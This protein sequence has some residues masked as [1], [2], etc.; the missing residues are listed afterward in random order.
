LDRDRGHE[1]MP[2]GAKLIAV[3]NDY[4]FKCE[5]CDITKLFKTEHMRKTYVKLHNKFCVLGGSV[6]V[7]K[8]DIN[9]L[10]EHLNVHTLRIN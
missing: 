8:G 9:V 3:T 2:K 1:R 7:D 4:L 10:H 5:E 6:V